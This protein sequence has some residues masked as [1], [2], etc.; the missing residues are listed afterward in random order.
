[1]AWAGTVGGVPD[2]SAAAWRYGCH[3]AQ[4]SSPGRKDRPGSR[5]GQDFAVGIAG[6][7][8]VCR[9]RSLGWLA[10]KRHIPTP[11]WGTADKQLSLEC[12]VLRQASNLE[13][14]LTYEGTEEVHQLAVGKAVTDYSSF[15]VAAGA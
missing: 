1:M 12:P 9:A 14:V 3:R 2:G 5:I 10:G 13:S 7:A 6:H 8:V 11:I 4:R 15:R